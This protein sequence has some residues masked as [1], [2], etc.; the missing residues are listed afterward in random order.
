M[1]RHQSPVVTRSYWNSS[2]QR[3]HWFH[4]TISIG[5]HLFWQQPVHSPGALQKRRKKTLGSSFQL[6]DLST[7]NSLYSQESTQ[8][9][10]AAPALLK[11]ICDQLAAGFIEKV[12]HSRKT[13]KGFHYIPHFAVHK[14][15]ANTLIRIVQDCSCKTR[16]ASIHKDC[17]L[18]GPSLQNDIIKM[19]VRFPIHH[20]GFS[21][22]VVAAISG[23]S[24]MRF[25]TTMI[26][27]AAK[28]FG[29]F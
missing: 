25:I 22:D 28:F 17:L 1:W 3:G 12:P 11:I 24:T 10:T 7:T 27:L 19:F 18:I 23:V 20:V 8:E 29:N 21:S 4:G 13:P 15:S 16:N 6:L 5:I 26:T 9:I 2:R 14:D